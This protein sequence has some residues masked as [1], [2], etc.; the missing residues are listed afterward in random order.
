MLPGRGGLGEAEEGEARALG[1]GGPLPVP[2][3]GALFHGAVLVAHPGAKLLGAVLVVEGH[4]QGAFGVDAKG[5]HPDP[6]PLVRQKAEGGGL[7]E[8]VQDELGLGVQRQLEARGLHA[9]DEGVFAVS[10]KLAFKEVDA[11]LH[12]PFKEGDPAVGLHPEGHLP[13][14][15]PVPVEAEGGL[16]LPLPP[17][18]ALVP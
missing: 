6:A 16:K 11:R 10:E 8:D 13:E 4:L 14:G 18:V 17:V 5:L 2:G 9:E 3:D 15:L 12:L 1:V 7:G